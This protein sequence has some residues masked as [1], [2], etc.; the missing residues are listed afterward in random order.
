M[1]WMRANG[2]SARAR[3][4]PLALTYEGRVCVPGGWRA[5]RAWQASVRRP[6][7]RAGHAMIMC[8]GTGLLGSDDRAQLI[9]GAPALGERAQGLVTCALAR[10]SCSCNGGAEELAECS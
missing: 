2:G 5:Q 6:G 9:A 4:G 1:S 10:V 3:K 7:R 8:S